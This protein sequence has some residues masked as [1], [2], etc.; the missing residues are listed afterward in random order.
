METI[1]FCYHA[2]VIQMGQKLILKC[3]FS[4]N[5]CGNCIAS[6]KKSTEIKKLHIIF[7]HLILPG[8]HCIHYKTI[9]QDCQD[10]MPGTMLS[11]LNRSAPLILK[12]GTIFITSQRRLIR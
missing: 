12:T 9:Y 2:C 10:Y 6:L 11:I 8:C 3:S 7:I 4:Q 1:L 5:Y